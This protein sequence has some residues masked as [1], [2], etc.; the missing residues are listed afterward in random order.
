MV[1]DAACENYSNSHFAAVHLL[2]L[3]PQFLCF[4]LSLLNLDC[5]PLC[6]LLVLTGED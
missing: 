4:L 6:Q 1:R 5:S 2:P 3:L